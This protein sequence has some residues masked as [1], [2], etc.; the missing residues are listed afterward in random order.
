MNVPWQILKKYAEALADVINKKLL[1]MKKSY[2]IEDLAEADV[3]KNTAIL[4][5]EEYQDYVLPLVSRTF[6]L[7]IPQLPNPLRRVVAN[8]YLLCRT[9]DT[10]EDDVR[11]QAE[12]KRRYGEALIKVITG[13]LH[14]EPFAAELGPLL[15]LQ[16]PKAELDLIRQ[17]SRVIQ[18]THGFNDI[19]QR[20]IRQCI[21]IMSKG[22]FNFQSGVSLQG[23]DTLHHMESY[24]YNVAGVVG[25]M[26]TE[27]F[28]NYS[29]EIAL[30]RDA[31]AKLS[32]SFGIGLQMT[33]ILKDQWEDRPNGVCWLP[34]DVLARHGVDTSEL[35]PGCYSTAYTNA[36]NELIGITHAHLRNGLE[37]MLQIPKNEPGIRR[38]CY[39]A[40]YLAI[41]TLRN[42]YRK[43]DFSA[44]TEIKVRRSEVAFMIMR[45]R[46][47]QP[48]NSM[49]KRQLNKVARSIPLGTTG[50]G[51]KYVSEWKTGPNTNGCRD[52]RDLDKAIDTAREA[53]LNLQQP[54]G[55][56]S[57]KQ[58]SGCVISADY[59]LMMHFTGEIDERL[60][61]RL[62]H[63]IRTRQLSAQGG[64][65]QYPGGS[66]DLSCTVKAY[67]ALKLA[68]DHNTAPHMSRAREAIQSLGGA[69]RS[70]MLTRI[71]LALFEQLPWRAAPFLPVE[72]MLLPKWFPF[73]LNKFSCY[74]RFMLVPFAIFCT[75]KPRAKNP[76]GVDIQ[77]LFIRPPEQEKHYF[78]SDNLPGKLFLI[79]DK[80]CRACELLIPKWVRERATKR[81]EQWIVQRLGGEDGPG[82]SSLT[83][84]NAYMMLEVLNY[85]QTHPL[86]VG[87]LRAL[88]K[89]QVQQEDGS[90]YIQ[91]CFS[92][93]WDTG[94]AVA[95]LWYSG[96]GGYTKAAIK[97]ALDWLAPRQ[98]R[99]VQGDWALNTPD[100]ISGGWPFQY[101]NDYCPDLD[102]TAVVATLLHM[103]GPDDTGK[104]PYEE[105][106]QC[107]ADWLA[108]MQSK[109]GGFGAFEANNTNTYLNY[110]P[111]A[112]HGAMTGPPTEDVSARILACL[113]MLK[114]A[115]DSSVM[116]RCIHYLK[117]SQQLDGSFYG[118]WATN[119]I[120]GTWSVLTGFALAGEDMKQPWIYKAISWLQ[121]KQHADGGWGETCKTYDDPALRGSNNG[122]SMPE[123]TAWAVMALLTVNDANT[124]SIQ[125]GIDYLLAHQ[126]SDGLWQHPGFNAPGVP[127]LIYFKYHG[128]SAYFPLMA[129]VTYQQ[130]LVKN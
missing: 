76:N 26:L 126:Q 62:A 40:I 130:S 16:T 78:F 124:I 30:R 54:D 35:K 115:K 8:A 66:T 64:W 58:E 84:I 75:F 53:L 51:W 48:G 113:G 50:E 28:C 14:A 56:W 44:A 69:T 129:L 70:N 4:T 7:T 94:W 22:M 27:L 39:W 102:D 95:A 117:Q 1:I 38:F 42:I 49:L 79:L 98:V 116:R 87:V 57:F 91:P 33:N 24:C 111:Y 128:Y 12:Q 43:P 127:G 82:S 67:Y 47:I 41:C 10:I 18:I 9:A 118:C 88:Q 83:G 23:L 122:L 109:N 55:H 25:E 103:A 93:T 21:R 112:D 125:R 46:L 107:A 100:L 63:Y 86:R 92:P 11:L 73:H 2:V 68:G 114:R 6:A 20:A 19:E 37:Y 106:I 45:T 104:N 81:A 105:R 71:T 97:K 90:S 72:I 74:A 101:R 110:I 119:Y 15:S 85:P 36:L 59:I 60:Q 31:M 32:V 13:E 29:S 77:E 17:L 34:R 65:E 96:G 5:A 123:V 61:E 3:Q 80:I 89:L 99:D 108:G 121:S 120:Y 52:A